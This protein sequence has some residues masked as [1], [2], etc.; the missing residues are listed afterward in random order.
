MVNLI[1]SV[2][3]SKASTVLADD[4]EG[5][6]DATANLLA[7]GGARGGARRAGAA[8]RPPWP[9]LVCARLRRVGTGYA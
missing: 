8:R 6:R 7:L 1:R 4:V 9:G 5:S 3:G 2:Q